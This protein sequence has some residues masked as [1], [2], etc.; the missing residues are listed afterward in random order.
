MREPRAPTRGSLAKGEEEEKSPYGPNFSTP[1][2]TVLDADCTITLLSFNIASPKS[3]HLTLECASQIFIVVFGGPQDC[4][5]KGVRRTEGVPLDAQATIP[6]LL[7][8]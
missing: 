8:A 6:L 7:G 5:A 3:D 1:P 4:F 2:S